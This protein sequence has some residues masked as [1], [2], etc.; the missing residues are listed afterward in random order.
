MTDTMITATTGAV[1]IPEVWSAKMIVARE[2]YLVAAKCV[3][4]YDDE[5][6]Q[7]GDTIHIPEVSNLVATA[8]SA[9]TDVTYQAVTENEKTIAITEHWETSFLIHDRFSA[10][11]KYRYADKMAEKAGYAL[12]SKVD[13]KI[14]GF[15]G[16]ATSYVG[17]G[18]TAITEKN[19]IKANRLLDSANVPASDRHFI[20]ESYGKAQLN[21]I[22]HFILYTAT[23]QASPAVGNGKQTNDYGDIWGVTVHVS[24]DVQVA[25]ATPNVVH[26]LFFHK[27]A[28]GL[29]IQKNISTETQRLAYKL[30][31]LWV[32]QVLFGAAVLRPDHMVDFRYSQADVS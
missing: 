4:R 6:A 24:N 26:G 5:V 11:S 9:G 25:T 13:A 22:D 10:Q 20:V 18:S 14:L 29:A 15:Y 1:M 8:V 17:D 31:D 32:S 16:S 2:N 12:G 3:E 19:I 27:E 23:G 30:A 28:I 21:N 7:F